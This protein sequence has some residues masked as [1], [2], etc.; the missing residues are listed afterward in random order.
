MKRILVEIPKR[1][2]PKMKLKSPR[3]VTLHGSKERH[4]PL[5]KVF[6]NKES[7]RTK[8]VNSASFLKI[9]CVIL[10][11]AATITFSLNC[12]ENDNSLLN[13]GRNTPF[14]NLSTHSPRPFL[15]KVKIYW[16]LTCCSKNLKVVIWE[17]GLINWEPRR[18]KK[19]ENSDLFFNIIRGVFKK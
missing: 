17:G 3:M 8:N 18:E 4:K 11:V 13:Y 5:Y 9:I 2:S 7:G 14:T 16:I 12:E 6:E 1:I 19:S 15:H 10:S